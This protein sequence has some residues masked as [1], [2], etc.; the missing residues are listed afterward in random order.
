VR[1]S[2]P[3]DEVAVVRNELLV[4]KSAS[5]TNSRNASSWQVEVAGDGRTSGVGRIDVETG[6]SAEICAIRSGEAVVHHR[7][8]NS[9]LTIC[10]RR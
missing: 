9:C 8:S 5:S 6:V 3:D 4:C 1:F 10:H 7:D 2:L